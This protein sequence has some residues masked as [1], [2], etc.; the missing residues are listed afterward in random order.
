LHAPA[1]DARTSAVMRSVTSAIR[2]NPDAVRR[3][4]LLKA[5][6]RS[7]RHLESLLRDMRMR[8]GKGRHSRKEMRSLQQ[9]YGRVLH[10]VHKRFLAFSRPE[11]RPPLGRA[12]TERYGRDVG[13]QI[14]QLLDSNL[15]F[16]ELLM[17]ISALISDHYEQKTKEVMEKMAEQMKD[18]KS[19]K[20]GLGRK[21]LGTV[22]KV[23]GAVGSAVASIYGS[24]AAGAAVAAGAK[25]AA[26]AAENSGKSGKKNSKA[27][28]QASN[29]KLQAEMQFY[30]QKMKQWHDVLSNLSNLVH[31][32]SMTSI[33]KL[34]R[35]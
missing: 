17:R 5:Q 15:P 22:I 24:P 12:A 35:V 10:G 21:I 28:K 4:P 23:V 3:D 18:N 14:Q 9:I 30:V 13:N 19:K 1:F 31:Q 32:L 8:P 29:N 20:K 25:A 6:V 33:N 7:L 34:K 16:D 27:D 11:G 2:S 26:D